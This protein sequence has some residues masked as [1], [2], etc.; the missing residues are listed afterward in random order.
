MS[1]HLDMNNA[2]NAKLEVPVFSLKERIDY[3]LARIERQYYCFLP[4]RKMMALIDA[5]HPQLQGSWAAF[6]GGWDRLGQDNYMQ[7]GGRYRKRRHAVYSAMTSGTP[8]HREP[9]QPHYQ[10]LDYNPLNGGVARH[11]LPIQDEIIANPVF[12]KMMWLCSKIFGQLR[13]EYHWHIEVHQF[14]IET[15]GLSDAF[16]TPEGVHRDGVDFVFM[17][18]VRRKNVIGGETG[19]YRLDGTPLD[20]FTLADE[21]D[22]ALVNDRKVQHGVTPILQLDT[23]HL[24]FRDVLVITFRHK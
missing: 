3:V 20:Q 19:V 18:M 10:S 12:V 5:G 1:Q 11:Y 17:L 24:G 8:I 14:R 4:A 15:F 2:G 21:W 13:P 9:N 7:D 16:P 23:S 22:G 6:Q